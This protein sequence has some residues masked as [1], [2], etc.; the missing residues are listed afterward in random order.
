MSV[1]FEQGTYTWADGRK[2]AGSWQDGK[3]HGQ[4][5]N[6]A[7]TCSTNSQETGWYFVSAREPGQ[8]PI[9]AVVVKCS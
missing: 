1:L 9:L 3:Q 6:T 8:F 2:H 5:T 7:E 4:V